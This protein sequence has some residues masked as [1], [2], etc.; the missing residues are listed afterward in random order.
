MKPTLQP[1]RNRPHSRAQKTDT[2]DKDQTEGS[3]GYGRAA[4]RRVE[5]DPFIGMYGRESFS[6]GDIGTNNSVCKQFV[7]GTNAGLRYCCGVVAEAAC[8][9]RLSSYPAL[10]F[11]ADQPISNLRGRWYTGNNRTRAFNTPVI[12][13]KGFPLH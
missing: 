6:K 9:H 11:G 10:E 7:S 5:P 3:E 1:H 2:D 13:I 4:D 8:Q 12:D